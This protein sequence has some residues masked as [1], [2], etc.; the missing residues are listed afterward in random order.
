MNE[1]LRKYDALSDKDKSMMSNDQSEKFTVETPG[2]DEKFGSNKEFNF[3]TELVLQ[4]AADG[5]FPVFTKE[6]RRFT[7]EDKVNFNIN[8]LAEKIAFLNV[9]IFRGLKHELNGLRPA[10]DPERKQ[11]VN[12]LRAGRR[13]FV[14][15]EPGPHI[16][17]EL[18][19]AAQQFE[20]AKPGVIMLPQNNDQILYI[21]A[22]QY[23]DGTLARLM[24]YPGQDTEDFVQRINQLTPPAQG[25]PLLEG[26]AITVDFVDYAEVPKKIT[27]DEIENWLTRLRASGLS[28]GL[29][30][31]TEGLMTLDNFL[32]INNE[33]RWVDG[34]IMYARIASSEEMEVLLAEHKAILEHYLPQAP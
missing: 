28:M 5:N 3:T 12:D 9:Q 7:V 11:L 30:V 33:L 15:I 25:K 22:I 32:R 20:G 24:K 17:P 14:A 1:D 23:P 2:V 8:G 10:I 27:H 19:Y 26:G 4:P 34:N 18:N 16:N 6:S 29:D 13:S 21:T 31:S